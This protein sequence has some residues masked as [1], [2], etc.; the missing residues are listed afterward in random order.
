MSEAR[1]DSAVSTGERCSGIKPV[2]TTAQTIRKRRA[3]ILAMLRLGVN[4][5]RHEKLI[6][7]ER[8]IINRAYGF[9]SA[10]A[11]FVLVMVTLGPTTRVPPH[12]RV[13]VCDA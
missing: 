13:L 11:A 9:H 10:T 4:T 8:L 12:E 7:R 5:A 2:V 6:R 1:Y 3:C